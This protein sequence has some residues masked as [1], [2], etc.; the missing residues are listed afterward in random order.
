MFVDCSCQTCNIAEITNCQRVI[1]GPSLVFNYK[2]CRLSG[3]VPTC[4]YTCNTTSCNTSCAN[5]GDG[6]TYGKCVLDIVTKLT[7]CACYIN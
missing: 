4:I 1:P 5:A 2:E 6:Y 7:T 3:R